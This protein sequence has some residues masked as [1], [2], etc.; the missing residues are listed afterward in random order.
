MSKKNGEARNITRLY[1][2]ASRKNSS[3]AP[4][5]LSRCG[6]KI[7]PESPIK[8]AQRKTKNTPFAA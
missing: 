8:S 6:V 4:K 2:M 7:K 1:A 3:F 5:I